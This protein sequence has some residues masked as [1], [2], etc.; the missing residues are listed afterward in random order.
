MKEK[1]KPA[2]FH[3]WAAELT[4]Q[5]AELQQQVLIKHT[6]AILEEMYDIL[7]ERDEQ[8]KGKLEEL[9]KWA[10][11]YPLE[12]FPEPDLK[13]AAE[14]LGAADMTLDAISAYVIRKT[15][16]RVKEIVE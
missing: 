15:L 16:A 14:V 8:N 1:P 6:T 13:R 3:K 9:R 5:V 7:R 11:A 10:D 2:E 4:E 12:V